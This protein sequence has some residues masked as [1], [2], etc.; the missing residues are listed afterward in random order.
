MKGRVIWTSADECFRIIE[1]PDSWMDF[2]DLCGDTYRPEVHPDIPA[3]Q[4]L[5]EKEEFRDLVN[6][7]GVFGYILEQWNPAPGK[8]WEHVDSCWGFV[9]QYTKGDKTFEHYIVEEM[10]ETAK[11]KGAA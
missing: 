5:R 3:E 9:G 11:G 7:E 2:E 1:H 8:G 10:I 4:V 6:R